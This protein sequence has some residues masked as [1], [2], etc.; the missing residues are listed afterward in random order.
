[1][2]NLNS[3]TR[4]TSPCCLPLGMFTPVI[5]LVSTIRA[6]IPHSNY[7]VKDVL[8]GA[9]LV[10]RLVRT[11]IFLAYQN[12]DFF[13]RYKKYAKDIKISPTSL[14]YEIR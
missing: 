8:D 14:K 1:M 5:I 3:T 12:A 7:F 13:I 9:K 10:E 11:I 2:K 4:P 6:I